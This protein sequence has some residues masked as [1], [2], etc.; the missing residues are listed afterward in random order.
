MKKQVIKVQFSTGDSHIDVVNE[1]L[2]FKQYDYFYVGEGITV[3]AGQYAV[4][5][6]ANRLKIVKVVGVG[7]YSGKA[8]KFAIAL[9][10]LDD[11]QNRINLCEKIE[12]LK[13]DIRIRSEEVSNRKRLKAL[14]DEDE[15]LK[16]MFAE[17]EALEKD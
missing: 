11:H 5:R 16:A 4:V 15:Q 10:N 6:V 7:K 3:R 2:D 9:F 17:L 13:T 14:A 1:N 12:Q 8:N